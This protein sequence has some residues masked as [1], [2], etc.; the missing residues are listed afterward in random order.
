M[1]T[2]NDFE[3][4]SRWKRLCAVADHMADDVKRGRASHRVA[5]EWLGRRIEDAYRERMYDTQQYLQHILD[6]LENY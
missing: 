3:R 6:D 5:R 1:S 2:T 4:T